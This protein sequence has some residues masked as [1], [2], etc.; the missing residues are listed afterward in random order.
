MRSIERQHGADVA[1][2]AN[3]NE[4]HEMICLENMLYCKCDDSIDAR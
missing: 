4:E 2:T 1:G 3:K